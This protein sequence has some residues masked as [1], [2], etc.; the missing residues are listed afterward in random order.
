V[1]VL[2]SSGLLS[3]YENEFRTARTAIK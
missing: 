3:V 2:L 1:E